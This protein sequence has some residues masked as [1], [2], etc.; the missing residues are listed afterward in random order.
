MSLKSNTHLVKWFPQNDLLANP[1]VKLFITHC[2]IS[3]TFESALHGVPVVAVPLF[4]DQEDNAD[5]LVRRAKTGTFIDFYSVTEE[6]FEQAIKEVLDNPMY[7]E[8]A[9]KTAYLL[10]DHLVSPQE[11]LCHLV[12]FTIKS[13]GAP[14]LFHPYAVDMNWFQFHSLDVISFILA[15]LSVSGY[16]V[17]FACRLVI[18]YVRANLAGQRKQKAS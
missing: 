18:G 12:N 4:G 1:A 8:N 7:K 15:V 5:K 9:K 11:Q 16:L 6:Q 10:H 14:H 13:G 3:S 2:G 17:F